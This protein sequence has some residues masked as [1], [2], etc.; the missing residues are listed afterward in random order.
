MKN[1]KLPSTEGLP[2]GIV[3]LT[4]WAAKD[5]DTGARRGT[6]RV[7]EPSGWRNDRAFGDVV[8]ELA[9]G[10]SWSWNGFDLSH[11]NVGYLSDGPDAVKQHPKLNEGIRLI[12]EWFRETEQGK[13]S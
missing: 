7:S 12:W 11:F 10:E 2:Y 9:E 6:N 8:T 4:Q 1:Q 3:R 5:E 13:E